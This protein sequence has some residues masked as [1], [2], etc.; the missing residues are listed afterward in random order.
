MGVG[1]LVFNGDRV[2]VKEV[3]KSG[4]WVIVSAAQR[5]WS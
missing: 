1:T 3:D 5:E 4:K 2:S